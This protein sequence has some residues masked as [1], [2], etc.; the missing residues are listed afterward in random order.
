MCSSLHP[1]LDSIWAHKE[2]PRHPSKIQDYRRKQEPSLRLPRQISV[3]CPPKPGCPR[4]SG[5]AMPSRGWDPYSG[6][7]DS[8]S[9]AWMPCSELDPNTDYSNP[10]LKWTSILDWVIP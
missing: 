8:S 10:I 6:L 7:A 5:A 4:N 2:S 3:L 1:G 9:L